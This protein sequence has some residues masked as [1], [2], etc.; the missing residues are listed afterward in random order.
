[1]CKLSQNSNL[2]IST[3]VKCHELLEHVTL[4]KIIIINIVIVIINIIIIIIIIIINNI[5]LGY[6]ETV[7]TFG[8]WFC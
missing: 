3:I 4:Y 1:M 5:P 8:F 7:E 2:G 6:E